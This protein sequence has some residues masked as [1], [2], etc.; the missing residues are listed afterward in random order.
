M[1]AYLVCVARRGGFCEKLLDTSQFSD[2]ANARQ[3]QDGLATGQYVREAALQ[4]SRS[5]KNEGRR[6]SRCWSRDYTAALREGHGDAGCPL[7]PMEVHGGANT[8]LQPME[9]PKQKKEDAQ[10]KL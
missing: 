5:M 1:G 10:R 7:Q 6:F 2:K 4:A 8:R 9:K 3:L